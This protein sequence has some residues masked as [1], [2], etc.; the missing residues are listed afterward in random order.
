MK[1]LIFQESAMAHKYLDGLKG[2]EIGASAHNPFGLDT[3]NVDYTDSMDTPFK[4]GEMEMC[5]KA[6][7][8]DVIAEGDKLPFK[9]GEWDFVISS[10]CIEHF[11]DPIAALKEWYRVIKPGGYIYIIAPHSYRVPNE[12]RPITKTQELVDRHEGRM[13]PEDVNWEGGYNVSTVTGINLN[14]RGHWQVWDT[15]AFLDLCKYL[16]YK[17]VDFQDADDKVGN[18]FAIVIQK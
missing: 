11:F 2:V 7:K 15:E 9:D 8:V 14:D 4:K 6:C 18:G 1:N 16:N 17:V 13:K 5:G 12:T 10:H 3:I